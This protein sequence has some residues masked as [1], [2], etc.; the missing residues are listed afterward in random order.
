M[1][2]E[3]LNAIKG[4]IKDGKMVQAAGGIT[5][6]TEQSDKLGFDWTVYSVNDIVVRK[7]YVAQANPVGTSAEN[8]IEYAE[9]MPLI[10][11]AY[12][13]KDGGIYVWMGEWVEWEYAGT[14]DDPIP[15]AA[16]MEYEYG[17]YYRDPT[18]SKV[19]LCERTG[20]AAGGK[21]TLDALP[22]ELVGQYFT[23]ITEK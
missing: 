1:Q 11:N 22:H 12:Y 17:K 15:A 21:I 4:A 16:G 14:Q 13:R 2:T 20:E 23:L 9:G 5:I 3:K 8:P 19:Y 6:S 7:E 10:N 18:D